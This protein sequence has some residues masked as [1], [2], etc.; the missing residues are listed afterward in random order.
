MIIV[1][2]TSKIVLQSYSNLMCFEIKLTEIKLEHLAVLYIYIY[3]Y[4]YILHFVLFSVF[5]LVLEK[6]HSKTNVR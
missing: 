5:L 4:I 3:I 1:E 2:F 6:G